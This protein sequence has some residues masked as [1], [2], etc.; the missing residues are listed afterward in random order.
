MKYTDVSVLAGKLREN[1]SCVIIGKEKETELML[2]AMFAGGHVL[3]EDVPGTFLSRGKKKAPRHI[4][5]QGRSF[6]RGTTL[7]TSM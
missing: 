1:I 6:L 4:Q 7:I 2:A 5:P 3:L